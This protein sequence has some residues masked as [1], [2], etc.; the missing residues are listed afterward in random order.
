M[1][2]PVD[3]RGLAMVAGKNLDEI[4][5]CREADL[6]DDVLQWE[7]SILEKLCSGLHAQV[8]QILGRGFAGKG[9]ELG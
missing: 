1:A 6:L 4:A 7:F 8:H 5:G 3:R 9:T 2:S